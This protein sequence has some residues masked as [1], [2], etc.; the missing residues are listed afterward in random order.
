M[1]DGR[2]SLGISRVV[3]NSE[4]MIRSVTLPGVTYTPGTVLQVR[5]DVSGTGTTQLNAKAWLSGTAEPSDW[6]VTSTDT[7]SVLQ[8]GGGV[9]ITTYVSGSAT[10]LPVRVDTP[11]FW[12]GPAG[13]KPT[14]G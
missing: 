2:V 8:S 7:T 5:L 10:V 14:A 3:S 9:G 1:A 12:A 6:Q 4:T 11:D 13:T